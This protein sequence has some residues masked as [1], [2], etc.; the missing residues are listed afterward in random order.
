MLG[1][2][3]V[4][5]VVVSGIAYGF[6]LNYRPIEEIPSGLPIPNLEIF[7]GFKLDNDIL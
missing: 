6:G 5:L 3:L 1:L 2:F 4:A 7:T